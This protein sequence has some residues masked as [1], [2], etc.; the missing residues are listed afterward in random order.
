MREHRNLPPL[1]H[2]EAYGRRRTRRIGAGKG[3]GLLRRRIGRRGLL[4]GA[5]E[6]LS[7]Y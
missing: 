4:K 3:G 2:W 5:L 6:S 7:I 1:A